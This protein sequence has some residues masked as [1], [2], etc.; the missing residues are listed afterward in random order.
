M[1]TSRWV[2]YDRKSK[3]WIQSNRRIYFYWYSFLQHA[4]KDPNRNV[5]WSVYD[6]WGGS[7]VVLNTKFDVWWRKRWKDLFGIPNEGD[8]PK[9]PLTTNRPKE[10]GLRYSLMV[11]ENR[12]K[13]DLW[14]I[15]KHIAKREGRKRKLGL[16]SLAFEYATHKYRKQKQNAEESSYRKRYTQS[17]VGRY[18]RKAET[19]LDNVCEGRFP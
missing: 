19:I 4:E 10:N 15:A 1:K 2:K 11:Y 18:K 13:G 9:F 8:I 12:D 17:K 5:D 16:T 3:L 14:E 7:D 6:G